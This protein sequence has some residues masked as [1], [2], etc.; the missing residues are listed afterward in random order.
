M[1][2]QSWFDQ[3]EIL[4]NPCSAFFHIAGQ[5]NLYVLDFKERMLAFIARDKKYWKLAAQMDK[6]FK[7]LKWILWYAVFYFEV[8]M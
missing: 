7:I 8:F 4:I 5:A 3:E 1:K 6:K 2:I